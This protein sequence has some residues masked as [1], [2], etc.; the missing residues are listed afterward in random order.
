MRV[1]VIVKANEE[2]EAGALPTPE[3]V[4]AEMEPEFRKA[5]IDIGAARYLSAVEAKAIPSTWARR[6]GHGRT[7]PQFL[8]LAGVRRDGPSA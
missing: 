6:L 1:M 7:H 4:A 2:S 5:G 3:Y 8:Y